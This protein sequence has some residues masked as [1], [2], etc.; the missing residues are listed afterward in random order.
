VIVN[1]KLG[2]DSHHKQSNFLQIVSLHLRKKA[3]KALLEDSPSSSN[4]L[5]DNMAASTMQAPVWFLDYTKCSLAEL[6]KFIKSR[7]ITKLST[8]AHWKLNVQG[9]LHLVVRLRQMDQDATFTRFMELPPELRVSIFE[10]LLV[11]KR[12]WDE[13]NSDWL[14]SYDDYKIHPAVLRTSKQIYAE[15]APILYD[16]DKPHITI[17]SVLERTWRHRSSAWALSIIH[18]G[19]RFPFHQKMSTVGCV[20]VLHRL[21]TCSTMETMRAMKTLTV[22]LNLVTPQDRRLA[23][24]VDARNAVATL[25]L[26]LTGASKLEELTIKLS[27]ERS[28]IS[29]LDLARLLWPL[30]LLQGHITV[31]FEGIPGLPMGNMSANNDER[32]GQVKVPKLYTE[33]SFCDRIAKVGVRCREAREYHGFDG[34]HLSDLPKALD[35]SEAGMEVAD[36]VNRSS[37]WRDMQGYIDHLET[38]SCMVGNLG[39]EDLSLS[40]ADESSRLRGVVA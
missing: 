28:Q 33:H 4:A 35:G 20:S 3:K 31:K 25:C 21:F 39:I 40:D 16:Q 6:R 7:T 30:I 5:F 18:P 26:S 14:V 37:K 17:E 23:P 9:R 27:S 22:S 36:I 38:L 32:T 13:E 24:L 1:H 2:K 11:D 19:R 10:S 8:T 34:Y 29:D 12:V 15:A